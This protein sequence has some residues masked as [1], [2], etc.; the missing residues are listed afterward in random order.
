[1]L[2]LGIHRLGVQEVLGHGG[3]LPEQFPPEKKAVSPPFFAARGTAQPP[4]AI[5]QEGDGPMALQA[6]S[7]KL[8]L[9]SS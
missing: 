3:D 6:I 1:M 4:N 7:Q 9:C 2:G 5:P 8:G